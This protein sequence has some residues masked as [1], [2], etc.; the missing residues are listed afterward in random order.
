MKNILKA[1][2]WLLLTGVMMFAAVS[3]GT[4]K[5]DSTESQM[6]VVERLQAQLSHHIENDSYSYDADYVIDVPLYGPKP[7]MDSLK[8]FL[9]KEL[10]HAFDLS[11][12][13][14]NLSEKDLF[15]DDLTGLLDYYMGKF[16]PFENN[17]YND[18]AFSLLLIAQTDSFVTYGLEFLHCGANCG[19]EF[20]CYTFSKTDGH[21][22][23]IISRD[24]LIRFIEANNWNYQPDY[25]DYCDHFSFGLLEDGVLGAEQ[26]ASN[27]HYVPWRVEV[28]EM[29]PYLSNDAQKLIQTQGDI[30]K[31]DFRDW[32]L[33]RR[34][35]EAETVDGDN[36]VLFQ[37]LAR[38]G[39]EEHEY[40]GDIVSEADMDEVFFDV[41]AY[42]IK[43]G[44]YVPSESEYKTL[45]FIGKTEDYLI[46]VDKIGDGY[47]Y[48]A[49][50]HKFN[51]D[52]EPDLVL[53]NGWFDDEYAAYIFENKGYRYWVQLIN[54]YECSYRLLVYQGKELLLEQ[55]MIGLVNAFEN[56]Y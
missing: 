43:D 19:S 29:L 13:E 27:H 17:I 5:K 51:M 53:N 6:L 55:P 54:P 41:T 34:I 45:A 30:T 9:N 49:W 16:K 42:A 26:E 20:Y 14:T 38:W 22:C 24:N 36:V 23:E 47:H 52:N 50:K 3:C 2:L 25:D 12:D 48:S 32:S 39:F 1:N 35:G 28:E 31:Y 7:L 33:G 46:R 4:Q 11:V 56:A 40:E 18:Y 44:K 21:L 15:Q 37:H 8:V 10:F